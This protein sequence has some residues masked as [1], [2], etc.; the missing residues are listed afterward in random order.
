M[1]ILLD[2]GLQLHIKTG[3]GSYAKYLG[4]ALGTLP[5]TTV[6]R[7]AFAPAG[8]RRAARLSYLKYLNSAAYREKLAAFDVVHYANYALP[9]KHPPHTAVAVTVHDLTAFSHPETLPR[10]YALYNRFMVRRAMKH[11]DIVFTVS[12]AM[13]AEICARFP[14]AAK[15]VVAVHPGH[16]TGATADITPAVYESELLKGLAKRKFFLFVGTM[17]KRKNLT[18]LIRAYNLLQKTCP[19]AGEYALVL[20]GREGFGAKAVKDLIASA[21]DIADIRLPGFVSNADRAKLLGEAAAF[22]FPS[23]YE[24]FGS[25]QTEAMAAELPLIASDIPTN[26]EISG[27][28]AAYYPLGD[29][30]ALTALMREVVLGNL[31]A[32]PAAAKARLSR[33]DWQASAAAHR[34]ALE[35]AC[36]TK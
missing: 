30:S 12:N 34:Q 4:E 2:D 21:P 3:I 36:K 5:D 20:A 25:P 7:E 13:Q 35:A 31:K 11:A 19:A 6:T 28:Y 27:A 23:I 22:V 26:R 32:D 16:Y 10:A 9:K 17:E 18:E 1:N 8:G 29:E 24:G 14:R 15:K 33:Y